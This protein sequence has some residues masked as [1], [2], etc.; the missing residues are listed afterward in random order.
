MGLDQGW[1]GKLYLKTFLHE[2]QDKSYRWYPLSSLLFQTRTSSFALAAKIEY[3]NAVNVKKKL[4]GLARLF[5][6]SL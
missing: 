4:G 1:G 5:V 6:S 2:Q 3:T